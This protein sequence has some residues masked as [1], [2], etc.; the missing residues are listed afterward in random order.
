[1]II[2]LIII[3]ITQNLAF[4]MIFKFGLKNSKNF[5]IS[6]EVSKKTAKKMGIFPVFTAKIYLFF[7]NLLHLDGD[8]CTF[9]LRQVKII[10][11]N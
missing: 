10:N 11:S 9:C 8:F 3:K 7:S 5:K 4:D 1:M 6:A 2:G